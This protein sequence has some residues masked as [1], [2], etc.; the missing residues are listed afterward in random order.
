MATIQKVSGI[1]F[2]NISKFDAVLISAIGSINFIGKPAAGTLLL[3]TSYGS[4]AAA[5][6]SVRKLRTAYNGAAIQVQRTVGS[7]PTQEIGFDVNG[8]LDTATLLA[9]ASGNKVGVSIWY[10][11]SLNGN[12]A[13]QS[14]VS[15]R[16][17]VVAAGGAL[18]KE[19]G[20]ITLDFDGGDFLRTS[21]GV[22]NDEKLTFFGVHK[23]DKTNGY[24]VTFCLPA[25]ATT[26]SAP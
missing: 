22:A 25:N 10:D 14:S 19:G 24:N 2:A 3:D 23:Q 20:R 8:N 15:N 1:D 7:F 13:T 26:H 16:P 11:Q 5:A 12:N 17:I 18:V 9:Y 21:D 4:G 6:Y